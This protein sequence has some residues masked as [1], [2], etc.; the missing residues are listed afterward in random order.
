MERLW[1]LLQ[2]AKRLS[3]RPSQTIY[4]RVEGTQQ[5]RLEEEEED[6]EEETKPPAHFCPMELRGPEPHGSRPGQQTLGLW[7]AAGRR[8]T[9]YLFLMA[10]LIFTG[11]FL[12]GYVAFRGS[13]QA[14]GDDVLVV[15]EDVNYETGPD[16]HQGTLY[17]SDLQAMFLRHLGEGSLEDTIR[18]TSLRERVAGSAGMAALTQ[19]V[20]AALL[21]QKLDHVW[22]DTHYVGLQF[23][24]R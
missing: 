7:T 18:Q 13:C 19:D 21:R 2:G 10:L 16:S 14:C 1:G 8:A 11:A 23:P 3:P 17:W 6:I 4:K 12:L 22:T 20:R 15:S 9:P 24:D 5:G